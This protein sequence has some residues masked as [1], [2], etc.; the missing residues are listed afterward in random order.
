MANAPSVQQAQAVLQENLHP[1]LV[2]VVTMPLKLLP[3]VDCVLMAPIVQLLPWSKPYIAQME[4]TQLKVQLPVPPAL[5]VN[6][7][8]HHEYLNPISALPVSSP[9]APTKPLASPAQLVT[10]ALMYQPC[11][12]PDAKKATILSVMPFP[13]PSALLATTA[14]R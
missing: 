1:L 2:Q 6:S 9:H 14:P 12:Q 5:L 13:A 7:A 11:Y 10:A 8:P 4:L 3:T